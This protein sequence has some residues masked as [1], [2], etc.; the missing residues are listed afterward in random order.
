MD[1]KDGYFQV[2]L[3]PALSALTSFILPAELKKYSGKFKF[4]RCPQ[5]LSVSGDAFVRLTDEALFNS[6]CP[7]AKFNSQVFKCVD[8]ILVAAVDKTALLNTCD[9]ILRRLEAKN[10][11][12]SKSKIVIGRKVDYC[13]YVISDKGISPNED[14]ITALKHMTP[15]TTV[16]E[17]R[18]LLGALQQLNH[19]MPDLANVMLP[20]NDLLKKDRQFIWGEEQQQ[21]WERI[22]EI[23]TV[24]LQTCHFDRSKKSIVITDAASKCGLGGILAQVNA[25]GTRSL[26]ACCS[27]ALTDVET[28]YSASESEMLAVVYAFK[29][30]HLYLAGAKPGMIQ[31]FSDHRS[32]KGIMEKPLDKVPTT[33]LQGMR[34]KLQ[35]YT[36]TI[37]YV[38][39]AKVILA[40]L[41][42][43]KPYM[44]PEHLDEPAE[45]YGCNAISMASNSVALSHGEENDG[46]IQLQDLQNSAENC[47]EY[48]H[49]IA[50][51]RKY[52]DKNDMMRRTRKSQ[53]VVRSYKE[54]W[55]DLS[56]EQGLLVRGQQIILPKSYRKTFLERIH[57][58]HRSEEDTLKNIRK[59]FW[60]PTL[61]HEVKMMIRS[62]RRCRAKRSSHREM[63][64]KVHRDDILYVNSHF[65]L[66]PI[67]LDGQKNYLVLVE[68]YS[69]YPFVYSMKDC[70]LNSIM[71]VLTHHFFQFSCRPISLRTDA[72]KQFGSQAWRDF[73][74]SYGANQQES[75]P[76]H[77][78]SNSLAESTG[79]KKV[80]EILTHHGQLNRQCMDEICHMRTQ[81]LKGTNASP[82]ILLF[83]FRPRG[84]LPVLGNKFS[85]IDRAE[86]TVQREKTREYDEKYWNKHAKQLSLLRPGTEVDI[87]EHSGKLNRGRW[88]RSGVVIGQGTNLDEY[89]IEDTATGARAI[90]NRKFL[91]PVYKKGVH[92]DKDLV[93][94]SIIDEE[95]VEEDALGKV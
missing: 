40:D 81:Y 92:F 7:G 26:I 45:D 46:D 86:L 90:R 47:E 21:A 56:L 5:G 50:G 91:N 55:D 87:L 29:K 1:L 16:R 89:L 85:P 78:Q 31:V 38:P 82:Y 71:Q 42:S 88:T 12:V 79:V 54:V 95:V 94:E 15:P 37:S 32:L 27:R 67:T 80:K 73:C 18:S 52:K 11:K 60:Y 69:G 2:L 20:I 35:V 25:D 64:L 74:A 39:A 30:F 58:S 62:C 4:L 83:G 65:A 68:R 34:L 44:G 51:F 76:G 84:K 28:R 43:R 13:G 72:G 36:F 48:Q 23:L 9:E 3:S 70:T 66:D 10:I 59:D 19:Y 6:G 61:D 33:R 53:D 63:P 93:K 17:V 8:D 24:N 41:L 77:Q 57:E 49:I 14:R 75:S 22:H